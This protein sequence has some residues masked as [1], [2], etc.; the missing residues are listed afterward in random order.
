MAINTSNLCSLLFLL[1]LFLLSTTVSLA[2]SEFDR[3]E[4]EECKRQCMQLETSGQMRR[5]VS[6]CD[7][8]FEEDIDWSKYDNQDDPQTDCQQCQRRCRQQESGPR[9]QQYCQRRCKEICEEEEEY[10]R[11]RDPQQQYEQCQERCQRH[12]TEPRHMQTCQQR[13]ER[14]YEKEKRKQQKRYEEQQREDE[15]KYEERMKEED[16]KRDPQQ[17][18]YEDC[19]RRCEQQEPRQQYQCQRRC[20]E[21]QRQHGRGGDLINPQR[22][23]SGRY[24]EGEEKQSDN[25]YYFDERSLSTRFRTEEGHISVLENFYGRSKL[26]RALKNYRLVLLEANPNAFVLPTHLD[27]DAILLVTGGRGALKMIHRD[28]RESYNLECGDVIRIPAGTTFYLINRDNNERLH[29]AKF[30]QTI[31]TP[32]Q[33]KEFFPAGGQNPEPYLSTFSKEILEAALNTQAERL[34]GV[35]GQQREGVIISASQEQIRELTRDDSESR[36]W[37]IRRGGESSRGPYNLFNKRPLYSNKYGQAYEVKPED[38]RQL[39]DMD[40]SVF[41]ANITQGSMMGPFFNTRS[42]KVVVVASGEADVEMACPHLSG[43]HGGRRGGKRHEEEE[44]VHYE[45]VKAR[46]SKREAI[47]VPVGH[48]VVFVSSGNENLLL[49]AFGINAQNNHENF[50]AGRE[51]NV[52][53]QIEPQAMELAFAAPRKE[54][55]ELFNSQDE[56]IFF[57][58][59]RQH[60]QQ[61]SRSTKQQQPLVSILDFVGF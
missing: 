24:E 2:E 45:Q 8:R 7:K 40:V 58:G 31:S 12:E 30:L 32:G 34:R 14:R 49:F 29:I 51:R 9:Q 42:T 35:L 27:A 21:Q 6:Q 50:L 46:L 33:Y 26:L 37:H 60:Q 41:I 5:C 15:E 19:R 16:N 17:R 13:C 47:V 48:P 44:D 56:S 25:P 23:G 3:Q 11:Q 4:Y 22:G 54:V 39:Q 43:R 36:R 59:P 20:R 38:Y 10:N 1:S 53:Q 52:L 57:P 55:E 18:E 61:S 28:N